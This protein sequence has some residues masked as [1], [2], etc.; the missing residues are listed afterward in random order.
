MSARAASVKLEGMLF[1]SLHHVD[2]H[3]GVSSSPSALRFAILSSMCALQACN[4][5][6]QTDTYGELSTLKREVLGSSSNLPLLSYKRSSLVC[7]HCAIT[8]S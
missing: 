7:D 5:L 3:L 4:M 8:F 1:P 6:I 2:I